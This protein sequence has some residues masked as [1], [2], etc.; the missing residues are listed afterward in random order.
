MHTHLPL[1]FVDATGD[2]T[3]TLGESFGFALE[4]IV[5]G[6]CALEL[7][8]HTRQRLTGWENVGFYVLCTWPLSDGASA[9]ASADLY[10]PFQT[11]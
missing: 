1:R 9:G 10:V 5:A 2:V 6:L 8:L 4:E 7:R 11:S 3:E